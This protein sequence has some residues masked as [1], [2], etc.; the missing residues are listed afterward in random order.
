MR[1]GQP[2]DW[3]GVPSPKRVALRLVLS[4]AAI[5]LLFVSVV[6][7]AWGLFRLLVPA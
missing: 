1:P 4:L 5:A 2:D 7:I 6:A 3:D